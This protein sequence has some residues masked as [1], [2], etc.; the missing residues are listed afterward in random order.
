MVFCL[1]LR[2]PWLKLFSFLC[3]LKD[4]YPPAHFIWQNCPWSLKVVTL[5]SDT[6]DVDLHGR[7]RA[8]HERMGSIVIEMSRVKRGAFCCDIQGSFIYHPNRTDKK[9]STDESSR[10]KRGNNVVSVF[11]HLTNKENTMLNFVRN[12]FL[13]RGGGGGIPAPPSTLSTV[14]ENISF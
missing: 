8:V 5:T 10:S 7:L 4:I 9:W 14:T 12:L 1:L 11:L 2:P 13:W 6:R 3:V